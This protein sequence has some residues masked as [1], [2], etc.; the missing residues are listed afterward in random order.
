[1]DPL[2]SLIYQSE[3]PFERDA[4]QCRNGRWVFIRLRRAPARILAE[5]DTKE[6]ILALARTLAE[7]PIW[8]EHYEDMAMVDCI[9]PKG[10]YR[11]PQTCFL[12][13]DGTPRPTQMKPEPESHVRL[14]VVPIDMEP[15][16]TPRS[17]GFQEESPTDWK[18][19]VKQIL[20][21]KVRSL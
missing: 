9:P 21:K 3:L 16:E 17:A 2:N 12:V 11:H 4:I 14:K 5:A 19:R 6:E 10:V 18:A 1:M 15:P 8:E 13:T 20:V 7:M